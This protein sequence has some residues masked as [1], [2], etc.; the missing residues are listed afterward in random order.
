MARTE[1]RTNQIKDT[2]IQRQDINIG[3]SGSS[4]ITRVV[5]GNNISI[6]STGADSGTGIVTINATALSGITMT[7]VPLDPGGVNI[8]YI[9]PNPN[10]V[11][12]IYVLKKI[13]SEST[14]KITVTSAGGALIDG[15]SSLIIKTG[16][17]AIMLKPY[18]NAWYII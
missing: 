5:A 1:I 10:T 12:D 8:S 4:L 2:T 11:T 7:F 3:T 13:V 18:N 15:S 6:S 17:S 16:Y 14:W 9:L